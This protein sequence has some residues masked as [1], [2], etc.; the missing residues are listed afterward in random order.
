MIIIFYILYFAWYKYIIKQ[1]FPYFFLTCI[2]ICFRIYCIKIIIKWVFNSFIIIYRRIYR[3]YFFFFDILKYFFFVFFTFYYKWIFYIIEE[4]CSSANSDNSI[5][6]YELFI[7]ICLFL[8]FN[9]IFNLSSIELNCPIFWFK[10]INFLFKT[11]ILFS[12]FFILSSILF[13]LSNSNVFIKIL[14]LI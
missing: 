11:F 5:E 2:F 6:F 10:I 9:K 14:I 4:F 8:L 12:K 1:Y 3:F 13:I 7:L